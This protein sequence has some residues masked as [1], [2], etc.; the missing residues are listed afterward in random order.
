M[1]EAAVTPEKAPR[2]IARIVLWIGGLVVLLALLNL[3]GIDVW[4]WLEQLWESVTEISLYYIVLGCLF[5]AAQTVLT[6]LGWYGILRYAYPGGVTFMPV[7][8]S[9]AAGVALNNFLPANIGTFVTLL[10]FVA[11]VAGATFPGILAGYVV[12]KIFYLVVGTLIYVYLFAA[13]AGSFE[14]QFGNERD[15]LTN[16]PVLTLGIIAGGVLLIAL[17]VRV[18]WS[19][20]KKMWAKAK[21]GAAIL[22]D[23]RAYVKWVLLPQMGGYAAKVG[24]II[25]FLAAYGIPVTFGSVMSVLGSNQ[26]ANLLSFTPGGVGVNQAF[27]TFA[28]DSYTD[29]TT[30]TAYS[31]G[32]QLVTTAF[33]VCF[34]VILICIVFGWRGGSALVRTSYDD[35][36]V[37]AAEMKASRKEGGD[38]LGGDDDAAR[39]PSGAMPTPRFAS[40]LPG[41]RSNSTT[42]QSGTFIC[43]ISSRTTR[44]AE[45]VSRPKAPVSISTSRRTASPTRRSACSSSSP[46]SP[47]CRS[48][49]RR[50]S[51]ATG[52]TSP[53]TARPCTSPCACRRA[54]RSSSTV[55]TSSPRCTRCSSAWPRSRTASAP[56]EWTGHTGKPIRNVV[57]IGIGGSDLGPVMAYEALRHYSRRDLTFRFVS[58]VDSTDFAEATR[59]LDPAETLFIVAS[60]TF[61]TLET[62]TNARTARAWLLAALGDESA[63]AK[64]FVAVSTNAEEVAAFGIDP[65]N[66]FGFWDW[67]GGRYSLCSAIGLSTMIAI[68][69]DRFRELLAGFHAMDEHFRTTPLE[70]N[71]PAL[72]GLLCVWYGDFFGA[73]TLGVM[74]YSQYLKRFP[75]YLQQL[76]MES[77]GKQVTLDGRRVDYETGAV[78]WG[79]PGTNGQHSFFQLLHQGT[80]LVPVDLIGFA[81]ALDPIGDH[82]DL[83]MSNVFA[84]AEALAFGKTADEVRAEGTGR[85]RRPAPRVRGQPAVERDP[86][87]DADAVRARRP[88]R[89]V[90]AQRVHAGR[91]LGHRLVRP[92]GR[93]AREVARDADRPRA[94]VRNR[95]RARA[96]LV[97]ERAHP[98]LPRPALGGPP[99]RDPARRERRRRARRRA[100][101]GPCAGR[102]RPSR[103]LHL[104]RERRDDAVGDDRAAP[105]DA[106]LGAGR[107][108]PGGR[109][110]RARRRPRPQPHAAPAQPPARGERGDPADAGGGV[111]TS[112][113]RLP[114]TPRSLPERLDLVHLGLGAD[115]HT[116]SLVPGDPVLEV[117]DR[118]VA[119]TGEYQGR[120]RMTLT[121]PTLARARNVLWLVTGAD[122][123]DALR[124]LRAGDR[125]IPAGR[126]S[127]CRTR[128][129]SPTGRRS[130]TRWSAPR[131]RRRSR[132]VFRIRQRHRDEPARPQRRA[133]RSVRPPQ[134]MRRSAASRAAPP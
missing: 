54:R 71:L 86:R 103:P 40:A 21:Q 60:K 123:A 97:D 110:G 121:Y 124:R 80:K 44:P 65:D 117:V 78:V 92:V 66:V 52:S 29:S 19:W 30:A 72:H 107:A 75:A 62:M 59:D 122:K 83:L 4:G 33:N 106:A 26:L 39:T 70:R 131:T 90:R 27:N 25:V 56:D 127:D 38:L 129:S 45:S 120:R 11:I 24:V 132:H 16:H 23:L 18:F 36:K 84:Q 6:A 134:T 57:N 114:S 118:D 76:A 42:R 35:A 41:K 115:G 99:S 130:A 5:Q 10:M 2:R 88:R 104:R 82:H 73:Q 87:R 108:L 48:G 12:Q 8:A 85:G 101:R 63:I 15:A 55:S 68:G 95:A 28:L 113:R 111:R 125:S 34:A 102:R 112:R 64:H 67:V 50:C 81:R 61:T 96:R 17:L 7:L 79:E 109:A 74:P 105:V 32:Q 89:A 51:A 43:A 94:H 77:N 53:R 91:D 133:L 119:V 116:A 3:A 93:R 37:K 14:F 100:R 98:A 58:N 126:V 13:I 31:V 1:T 69:P 47:A 20:V 49:R 128:S 9:Y 22:G 46:R